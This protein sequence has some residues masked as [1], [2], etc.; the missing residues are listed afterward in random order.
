MKF[1][2]P[3]VLTIVILSLISLSAFALF[4]AAK[5]SPVKTVKSYW[6]YVLDGNLEKAK[7]LKS[8]DD[9]LPPADGDEGGE[10][11]SGRA[12]NLDGTIHDCCNG[13][14]IA[15]RK[16]KITKIIESRKEKRRAMVVVEVEDQNGE[17]EIY[18]NCLSQHGGLWIIHSIISD[19]YENA[20]EFCFPTDKPFIPK[21]KKKQ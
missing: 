13:K 10:Y 17:K 16:L 18:T 2:K 1:D 21:F 12:A 9:G 8:P 5:G 3:L 15:E 6:Q 14:E 7:E 4:T 20:D 11:I 19:L